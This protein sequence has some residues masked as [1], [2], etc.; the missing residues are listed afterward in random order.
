MIP[1]YYSSNRERTKIYKVAIAVFITTVSI[2]TAG[3]CF[4]LTQTHNRLHF[5]YNF[6][7]LRK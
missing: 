3:M 6:S 4:N 2:Y 5:A 1:G 7:D